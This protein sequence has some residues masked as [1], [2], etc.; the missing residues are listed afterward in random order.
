MGGRRRATAA[1]GIYLYQGGVYRGYAYFYPD[2][3]PL[4]QPVINAANGQVFVSFN[5]SQLGP[6]AGDAA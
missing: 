5:L 3:T 6:G 4:P 1:A 2:G